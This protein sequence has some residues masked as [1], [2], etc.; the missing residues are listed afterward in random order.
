MAYERDIMKKVLHPIRLKQLKAEIKLL[1]K[2]L[3]TDVNRTASRYLEHPLFRNLSLAEFEKKLPEIQLKHS[4]HV[5]AYEYG[6]NRWEDL[7]EEVVKNDL[8]FRSNGVGFVY[9][10]FNTYR[11]AELYHTNQGGYLLKFW[12][13]YVVCGE[14]YIRLL[15]LDQY[16]KEWESIG[17]NW[18]QPAEPVAY[19]KLYDKAVR[20]YLA[21]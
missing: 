19:Q 14:E 3:K 13:D 11:E 4:Y 20:E 10:W 7:K 15:Q 18:V 21:L 8:L 16:L 2:A 9:K 17:F 12:G 5:V 6:Y 1:H